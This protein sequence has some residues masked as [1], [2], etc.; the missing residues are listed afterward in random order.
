MHHR[1]YLA[2]LHKHAERNVPQGSASGVALIRTFEIAEAPLSNIERLLAKDPVCGMNVDEK[3][4]KL[5]SEV[6][7]SKFYF[8]SDYCKQKFDSDP[9]KYARKI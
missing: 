6:G 5:V 9:Q 2:Q 1:L 7:G 3:K 8:C 4:S